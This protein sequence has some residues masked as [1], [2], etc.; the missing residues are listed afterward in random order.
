L[1]PVNKYKQETY[2]NN[3]A[4]EQEKQ[5]FRKCSAGFHGKKQPYQRKLV[6]IFFEK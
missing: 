2:A 1:Q 5:F 4:Q 3:A 6:L